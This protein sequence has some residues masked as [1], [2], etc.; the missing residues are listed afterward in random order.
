MRSRAFLFVCPLAAAFLLAACGG[1]GSSSEA[2][3]PLL[4]YTL[5]G[6]VSGLSG[7]GLVLANGNATLS[8]AANASRFSFGSSFGSYA[9]SVATQPSGQTCSVSNAS[10]TLGSD[11]SNVA[12][13]CRNYMAYVTN[14][15]G[16]SIAQFSVSSGTGLLAALATPSVA[17]AYA[18]SALALSRDGVH[19]YVVHQNNRQV[20]FY[21]VA[22]SGLLTSAGSINAGSS[23]YALALGVSTPA[24]Y[25]ANY[26][27]ASISQ[28]SLDQDGIPGAMTSATVGSGVNPQAIALAPGGRYAYVA[29][30]SDDTI[31]LYSIASSGAWSALSVATISTGA[32]SSPVAL[33]IDPGGRYLYVV[34][35]SG[36]RVAQ[37]AIGT[38]GMLTALSPSSVASGLAPKS[39]AITPD[40]AYAYVTNYGSGTVSQ[41]AISSGR[42]TPLATPTVSAGL[43]PVAVAVSPDG[44]YAYVVNTND[45]TVSQYGVQSGGGLTPLFAPTISSGGLSPTSIAVR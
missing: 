43:G 14:S 44:L 3:A 20:G 40:G 18:P 38:G 23:S 10:G 42:L 41:Y 12:V 27:A 28:F 31:S 19:A 30:A 13:S 25:V 35:E 4:G 36:Q 8:I 26:G 2:S 9:V 24:L 16:N 37:Y 11:V 33:A 15:G 21:T 6:T 7:N 22:S 34:L 45:A 1:G 29:N 39:I 5:S 17:T 32:G